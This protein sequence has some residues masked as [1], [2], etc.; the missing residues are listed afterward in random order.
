MFMWQR[1]NY[2]DVSSVT[3]LTKYINVLTCLYLQSD[4]TARI[5]IVKS[6]SQCICNLT[7]MKLK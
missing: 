2:D 7:D 6:S 4:K 3:V 5:T 1:K